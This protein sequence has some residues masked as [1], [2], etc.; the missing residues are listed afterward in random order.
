MVGTDTW[1]NA[2]WANYDRLIAGNREW[3]AYLTPDAAHKIAYRNAERLF[4]REIGA[5]L[6]GAR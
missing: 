6:L 1:I 3:L 2:Q 5:K 4:G